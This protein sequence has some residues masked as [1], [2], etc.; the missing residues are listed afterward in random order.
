M[1]LYP[2]IMVTNE[3]TWTSFLLSS[4][5]VFQ[6][7]NQNN[8]AALQDGQIPLI[9]AKKCDN[10]VK[11]FISDNG[12]RLYQG[13]CITLNNDGDGGAGLAFYQPT[14]VALDSHCTALL[15]KTEMSRYT[16]LFIAMCISKQRSLFG[17]GRAI[18]ASRLRIFRL[19]LPID[20]VGNPD[21]SYMEAIM[22]HNEQKMIKQTTE[23]LCKR[24]IINNIV[25]GG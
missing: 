16:M 25:G 7:G 20:E 6:K 14:T 13:H 12:K 21:F 10:G 3:H 17:H 2:T 8:M 9:S 22:R 18:N 1:P 11:S 24:L 15:P 5:F 23:I 4:L 19:M